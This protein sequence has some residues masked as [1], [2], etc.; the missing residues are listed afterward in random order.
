MSAPV[1]FTRS[2][3]VY[4]AIYA[5]KNYEGEA[6][7][8]RSLVDPSGDG[9]SWLEIACGTGRHLP[10]LSPHYA[11][12]VG[13]DLAASMVELAGSRMPNV[14]FCVGDMVSF[15]V[16]GTFDV[17][18]CLF[19]SIGYCATTERLNSAIACMARHLNPGR[20]LVVEPWI[21]AHQYV[22]NTT[23][24]RY[25]DTPE[26]KVV[27]MNTNRVENGCAVLEFHHMVGDVNGV[28]HYSEDHI[29]GLF[30]KSDYES[31]FTAAGLTM[32]VITDGG[33]IFV[34]QKQ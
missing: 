1:P 2:A 33:L 13:M 20:R 32:S 29:L 19:G 31:A 26:L 4:D 10:F 28:E 8:V 34:G 11:R 9:A 15:D 6:A 12:L 18:S 23:H 5:H 3:E 17:V 14:E 21:F 30:E 24:A 25:V 27:R 16:G 22:P 7:R